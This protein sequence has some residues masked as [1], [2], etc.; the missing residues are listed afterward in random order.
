M[1][2]LPTPTWGAWVSKLKPTL[3]REN[4]LAYAFSYLTLGYCAHHLMGL[5][6]TLPSDVLLVEAR[7]PRGDAI[8][9]CYLPPG[10]WMDT[11]LILPPLSVLLLV[12][13]ALFRAC[14][15]HPMANRTTWANPSLDLSSGG[16]NERVDIAH[17]A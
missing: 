9:T 15:P 3:P 16:W 7:F 5:W 8:A 6:S 17:G 2:C 11:V 10:P 14:Q 1:F 13:V 12:T 4:L